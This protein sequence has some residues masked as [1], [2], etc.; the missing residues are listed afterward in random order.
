[1]KDYSTQGGGWKECPECGKQ[2]FCT[3]PE[4]AY[5]RPVS[6]DGK[7]TIW[8]FHTY[9]CLLKFDKEYEKKK[10]KRRKESAI[11]QHKRGVKPTKQLKTRYTT[12]YCGKCG[13][14][15]A[16]KDKTC[17]S[18]RTAIDWSEYNLEQRTKK[19]GRE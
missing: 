19:E 4:W 17:K 8:Y 5:K 13:R 6:V 7:S 16:L 15:V 2:F 14:V 18:C 1:M 10:Q 9:S 11:Q 3:G 12:H